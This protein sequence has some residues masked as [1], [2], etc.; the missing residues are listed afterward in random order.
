MSDITINRLNEERK[1]WRKDP[2]VGF[3]AR[4]MKNADNSTN[5]LLWEC[6]IP[7]PEGSDWEGGLF[8]L[9]M[10][11]GSDYPSKSPLCKFDYG[12]YHPNIWPNGKLLL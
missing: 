1:N 10:K 9:K 2:P 11:F 6:G 5:M 4:P 8:K 7:G 3:Y 12:I